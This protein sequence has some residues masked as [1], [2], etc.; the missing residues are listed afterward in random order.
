MGLKIKNEVSNK[1]FLFSVCSDSLL[2]L[3]GVL[4]VSGRF[5]SDSLLS[6]VGLFGFSA[7]LADSRRVCPS[8]MLSIAEQSNSAL[9]LNYAIGYF[10]KGIRS[11]PKTR[12]YA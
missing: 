9:G 7:V 6:C 2:F 10:H 12:K 5:C 1:G 8:S 3:K 4:A 11:I